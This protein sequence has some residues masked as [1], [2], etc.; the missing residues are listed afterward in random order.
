LE[1][2]ANKGVFLREEILGLVGGKELPNWKL[3]SG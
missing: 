1:T 3:G 2:V